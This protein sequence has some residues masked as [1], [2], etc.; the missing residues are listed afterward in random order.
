VERIQIKVGEESLSAIFQG[1]GKTAICLAHGAGGTMEDAL[2]VAM[3]ARLADLGHT[4]IRF[5]FLYKERGGRAPDAAPKLE[6]TYRAVADTIKARGA[7]RIFLG[8]KS[9]G[10]RYATIIAS[11]GYACDGLVLLGYP[12]HPPKQTTKLRDEHLAKIN[13][14][15]LFISGT[16]DPLCDLSLFRPIVEGLGARATLHLIDTGDHSLLVTKKSGVPQQEIYDGIAKA[17][18]AWVRR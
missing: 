6:S 17:I 11:K 1:T 8:G 2:V 3:T 9:M 16:R 13:T 4:T 12:L 7:E 18:D 15:M 5:N 14:P 10:G